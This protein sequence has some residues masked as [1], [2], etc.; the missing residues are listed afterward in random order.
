VAA[1]LAVTTVGCGLAAGVV[2]KVGDLEI[3]L[4][5]VQAHI[6]EATGSAWQSVDTRACSGLL[7]RYLEHEAVM[8]LAGVEGKLPAAG[9]SRDATVRRFLRDRCGAAP[10]VASEAVRQELD[11]RMSDGVQEEIH[12]RQ[13]LV[14][15]FE[16]ATEVRGRLADGESFDELSREVSRAPNADRGGELGWFRRGMLP[17]DI[18]QVVFELD[19]GEV[20]EPVGGLGGYHIFQVVEIKAEG[21]RNLARLEDSIRREL[22]AELARE[23]L[24]KCIAATVETVGITVFPETLWF[25]YGGKYSE[26]THEG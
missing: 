9:Q 22:E 25:D 23:H 21:D 6:E 13:L 8:A 14:E 5:E 3:D 16:I 18:E 19:E 15:N 17:E 2:A 26:E 24:Q 1:I 11:A 10:D 12:L 4:E 20:S 7:D